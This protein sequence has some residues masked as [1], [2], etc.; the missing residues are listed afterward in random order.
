[1]FEHGI[2]LA[3]KAS[4]SDRGHISSFC[5]GTRVQRQ[6]VSAFLKALL[7]KNL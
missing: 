4:N 6:N 5:N 1:M 7:V 3:N 2:S